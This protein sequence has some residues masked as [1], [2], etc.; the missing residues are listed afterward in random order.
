MIVSSA[1][2]CKV[3]LVLRFCLKNKGSLK[4]VITEKISVT[5]LTFIW[6]DEMYFRKIIINIDIQRLNPIRNG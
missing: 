5:E 1:F 6:N 4:K 3:V 2:D